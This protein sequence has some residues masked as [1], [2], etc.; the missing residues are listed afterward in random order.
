MSDS[1]LPEGPSQVLRTQLAGIEAPAY[2][3]DIAWNVIAYNDAFQ[4][5]LGPDRPENIMRWMVLDPAARERFLGQWDRYW[6]EPALRQL[7][8]A[9]ELHPNNASL[10]KLVADVHDDHLAGPIYAACSSEYTHPDGNTRP[11]RH[12]GQEA[13]GDLTICAAQPVGQPDKLMV[14]LLFHP[15][16]PAICEP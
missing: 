3:S 7:R 4:E 9:H 10:A 13:W 16:G 6:L 5:L 1:H 11:F 15:Y 8:F 12:A 2:L 14:I